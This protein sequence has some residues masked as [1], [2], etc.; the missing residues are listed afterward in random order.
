MTTASPS[1]SIISFIVNWLKFQISRVTEWTKITRNKYMLIL[2]L[3]L[4]F[5]LSIFLKL[6]K[7]DNTFTG[8]LEN[9]EQ[10]YI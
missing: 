10:S 7:Y 6:W 9:V 2:I 5:Y 3:T 8:D 4:F 1:L